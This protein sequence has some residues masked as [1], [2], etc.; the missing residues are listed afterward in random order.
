MNLQHIVQEN[1][2]R[3]AALNSPYNPIVGIG[4]P[5]E[6][7]PLWLDDKTEVFIPLSML[8]APHVKAILSARTL[9]RWARK[10]NIPFLD[11][12]N[13]L[14]R[15]RCMH[16]Y[17][18]WTATC[19]KIATKEHGIQP[20]ILNRPQR[21]YLELREKQRL[22]NEP[23]R[24]IV[25]KHRQWGCTTDTQIYFGWIQL[26]HRTNW[27]SMIVSDIKD[28]SANIRGMY[29]R[30]AS[31]HPPGIVPGVKGQPQI[32]R[33]Q[34]LQNYRVV[35]GRGNIIGISSV[36]TPDASRNWT[37]HMLHLSEVGFWKSTE[38]VNASDLAQGLMGS[39]VTAPYTIAV[40]ESTASGIGTYFE[41]EWDRAE[42]GLSN[43]TPL[44]VAWFQDPQYTMPVENVQQFWES[45]TEYERFM[46]D[47]GATL[48]HIRWYRY[49]RRDFE[50]HWRMQ[51]E[52]PTNPREAFQSTGQRVFTVDRVDLARKTCRPPLLVGDLVAD[53]QKGKK[54][55]S[56]IEFK[57]S[58]GGKLRIWTPPGGAGI[59]KPGKVYTNRY[60]AFADTGGRTEKA[61]YSVIR[62]LDRI[63]TLYGGAPAIVAEFQGHMDQD[64]FAWYCAR[65]ARWY[66]N[67]YLAIEVN[68]LY[69]TDPARAEGA[70]PDHAFTVLDE[71]KDFYSNLYYRIRPET[72][73]ERWDGVLGFHT[74]TATKVMIIDALNAALREQ[75][76][77]ERSIW[78]V[79]EFDAYEFKKGGKVMGATEK[80]HDD[81]VIATAGVVWLSG[82]MGPVQEIDAPDTKPKRR[83]R[84]GFAQFS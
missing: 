49:K 39:L 19:V 5:I 4:S 44:F 15:L 41:S 80:H 73:Q 56:N 32:S 45:L 58:A 9:E 20:F 67:A 53:S 57:E 68:K 62:V 46:W 59:E 54:A 72:I 64:L 51:A 2:R 55:F 77:E 29:E 36:E 18:Y 84:G 61:D 52:Y 30:M 82:Q 71:I 7:L 17:E 60:C 40:K 27:N 38:S 6:R 65:L 33:Y 70:E 3:H 1:E 14:N 10:A 48:E 31:L 26:F 42:K 43:D 16:D 63:W 66:N 11:A 78:A 76:Y 28:K 25:L 13:A 22:A 79:D 23:I 24:I 75:A 37:L 74:N 8:E 50:Q 83:L 12:V 47:R 35:E 69:Q 81:M 21:L 34:G